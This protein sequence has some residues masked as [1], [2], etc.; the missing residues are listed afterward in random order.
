M[1]P[2]PVSYVPPH[3]RVSDEAAVLEFMRA[4][5]FATIVSPAPE[6][7]VISHVP[8]LVREQDGVRSVVGHVARANPHWRLMDGATPAVAVFHGPHGYVS[9]TWYAT[10]PAVPTWNYGAVHAHGA[11]AARDDDGF[12]RGVVEELARR[13]EGDRPDSWRADRL[14]PEFYGGL[15][16]GIVAFQMPIARLDGKFKLGQNRSVED[17]RRVIDAL[18]RSGSREAA[19]LAEFMRLRAGV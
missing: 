3:F 18:E 2:D 1:A 16:R 12:A 6:E 14:A 19:W 10:A 13:Y 17:R 8:V 9:P 5:D 4:Y 7:L 11:P 15:L